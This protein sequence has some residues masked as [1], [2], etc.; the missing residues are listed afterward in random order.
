MGIPQDPAPIPA[1]L[2][3]DSDKSD[4]QIQI[5]NQDP[6]CGPLKYHNNSQFN[7]RIQIQ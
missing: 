6:S 4:K 1:Y 7:P 3:E 2:R 5:K